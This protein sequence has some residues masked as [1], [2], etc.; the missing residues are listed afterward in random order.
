MKG[1]L[2][3]IVPVAAAL[4][5]RVKYTLFDEPKTWMDARQ[6]C[7]DKGGHLASITDASEKNAATE[8]CGFSKCVTCKGEVDAEGAP[9][10]IGCWLGGYKNTAISVMNWQW[11]DA[12]AEDYEFFA[13]D[14]GKNSALRTALAEYNP[15]IPSSD[16][17]GSWA[18]LQETTLLPYVC[19]LPKDNCL[20]T[21][22]ASCQEAAYQAGLPFLPP[23]DGI[24]GLYGCVTGYFAEPHVAWYTGGSPEDLSADL[25]FGFTRAINHVPQYLDTGCQTVV[26]TPRPSISP[27][28]KTDEADTTT[29]AYGSICSKYNA[30]GLCEETCHKYSEA[31]CREAAAQMGAEVTYE[32]AFDA[33]E[34]P[35]PQKGVFGCVYAPS[36]KKVYYGEGGTEADMQKPLSA[37]G[38]TKDGQTESVELERPDNY[39]CAQVT[40]TTWPPVPK[41]CITAAL[42]PIKKGDTVIEVEDITELF[43]GETIIIGEENPERDEIVNIAPLNISGGRRLRRL[44]GA[45]QPG[46]LTLQTPVTSNHVL[47]AGVAAAPDQASCFPGEAV[48]DSMSLTEYEG[49]LGYL[50]K[51]QGAAAFVTIEHEGGELRASGNH[52]VFSGQGHA[53][54]ADLFKQGDELA[55]ADGSRSRVLAVRSDTTVHGMFAP[56]TSSGT[57]SVDGAMA[58]NY[59]TVRK[60]DIPHSVMHA[61]FSISRLLPSITVKETA[62]AE[63]IHPLAYLMHRVLK[64][65][66]ML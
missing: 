4:P 21:D 52:L 33:T 15:K 29:E 19:S 2:L 6:S 5:A 48:V 43:V 49:P 13:A 25:K 37:V 11:T 44:S 45:M 20:P 16:E 50:H 28:V 1:G 61:I 36:T 56:L 62:T 39:D 18:F 54:A 24:S 65:D 17:P 30:E 59:A 31:A 38:F 46:L 3:A 41:K 55:L 7:E 8:A 14:S 12:S 42:A 51:M 57:L 53:K 10:P 47:G 58:S 60:L 34:L 26:S 23:T 32:G 22:E 40:T 35:A 66:T 64:L 27:T 9:H 63:T